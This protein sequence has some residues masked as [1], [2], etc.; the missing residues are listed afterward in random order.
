ML[1][2]GAFILAGVSGIAVGIEANY[3]SIQLNGPRLIEASL[4]LVP[5]TLVYGAI[6]ALLA[7]RLPRATVGLLGAFAFASYVG[8]HLGPILKLPEWVQ[9][10]SP[11]NLYVPPLTSGVDQTGLVIMIGIVVA[12][13]TASGIVMR[14]RDIGA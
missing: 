11:F 12:A 14:R 13:L 5:F 4:L 3:Q 7:S 8:V 2:L 1:A 9:D 10:L 6:G